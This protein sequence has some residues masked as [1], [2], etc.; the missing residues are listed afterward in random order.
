MENKREILHYIIFGAMTTFVNLS[1]YAVFTKNLNLDFKT[2]TTAAWVLSVLFAFFTNKY[3]VFESKKTNFSVMV[4]ELGSFLLSRVLSYGLDLF[5]MVLL[6]QI[7]L[8]DDLASKIIAN[9]FVIL[10]N[11]F[12][13]K[14]F[15]FEASTKR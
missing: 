6:V 10:F 3:Y 7:L 2:G 13:S 11:Y 9:L 15:V 1:S 5:T 12:A 14:F 4:K 8:V